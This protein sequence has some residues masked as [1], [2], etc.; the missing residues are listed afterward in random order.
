[1]KQCF[2]TF[3]IDSWFRKK[4]PRIISEY[5]HLPPRQDSS[6]NLRSMTVV[7]YLVNLHH[8]LHTSSEEEYE[9]EEHVLDE[10]GLDGLC[11]FYA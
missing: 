5:V 1:M 3:S 2:W 6:D 4:H 9:D 7:P 11:F 8:A 10:T